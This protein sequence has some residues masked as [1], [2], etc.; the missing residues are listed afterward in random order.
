MDL[1]SK[2]SYN[3]DRCSFFQLQEMCEIVWLHLCCVFVACYI[4]SLVDS[5]NSERLIWTAAKRIVSGQNWE[6]SMMF[7]LTGE[8]SAWTAAQWVTWQHCQWPAASERPWGQDIGPAEQDRR[9]ALSSSIC[10][11]QAIHMSLSVRYM[12]IVLLNLVN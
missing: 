1:N 12:A 2:I 5:V 7:T 11:L 4:I 3:S 9:L 8:A 10:V 6:W